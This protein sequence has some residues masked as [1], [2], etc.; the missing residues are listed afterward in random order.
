M[1][2]NAVKKLGAVLDLFRSSWFPDSRSDLS[3]TAPQQLGG[4]GLKFKV[5]LAAWCLKDGVEKLSYRS[6]VDN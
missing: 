5:L 2:S 1:Q 4:I 3:N 6:K